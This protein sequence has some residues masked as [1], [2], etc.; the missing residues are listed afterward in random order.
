M[1]IYYLSFI[2]PSKVNRIKINLKAFS[3]SGKRFIV[4]KDVSA[5][6]N[7]AIWELQQQNTKSTLKEPLEIKIDFILP[8]K[9]R[10]DLDNIMKTVGD[11]LVY[12]G[13]IED[14][15]LIFKQTLEKHI[16]KGKEGVIIRIRKYNSRN[17]SE[18]DIIKLERFKRK[19]NGI[20]D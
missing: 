14:D 19:V 7:R 9:R 4:P 20:N 17:I 5:K 2:P 11:C 13:I 1:R 3:K 16:I 12:A 6:I 18:N 8:N 10:R 15:S